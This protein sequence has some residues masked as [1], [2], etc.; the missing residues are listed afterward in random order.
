MTQG[1]KPKQSTSEPIILNSVFQ[2]FNETDGWFPTQYLG[3][4]VSAMDH[5]LSDLLLHKEWGK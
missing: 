5:L 3:A 2:T 1:Y 4:T